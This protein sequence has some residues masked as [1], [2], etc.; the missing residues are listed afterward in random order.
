MSQKGHQLSTMLQCT[1]AK[2]VLS[3]HGSIN[4]PHGINLVVAFIFKSLKDPKLILWEKA[5]QG[6]VV[7]TTFFAVR[8]TIP[9][10]FSELGDFE[11]C[12]FGCNSPTQRPRSGSTLKRWIKRFWIKR[13][14]LCN[15][16]VFLISTVNY[17][18]WSF[19]FWC[20]Y[21]QTS[22]GPL[23]N[24]VGKGVTWP[25]VEWDWELFSQLEAKFHGNFSICFR[26][27][28]TGL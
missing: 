6:A 18:T 14:R 20:F 19:L 24:P 26:I 4:M 28:G 13:E 16:N 23:A 22:E 17:H 21:F 10:K 3:S 7:L 25:S 8:S 9:R 12:A 11:F 15:T 5:W 1:S 27:L 2:P